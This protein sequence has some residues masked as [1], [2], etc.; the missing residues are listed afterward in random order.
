M[1]C[2]ERC[3]RIMEK[4][5]SFGEVPACMSDASERALSATDARRV[6]DVPGK[7]QRLLRK[8]MRLVEPSILVIG[9]REPDLKHALHLPRAILS[10]L[11]N[12]VLQCDKRLVEITFGQI[13]GPQIPH[14]PGSC[15]IMWGDCQGVLLR[16]R[17]ALKVGT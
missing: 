4:G 12:S 17:D 7:G 6:L 11:L 1:G 15:K 10:G 5:S 14:K 13:G 16:V 3:Q 9:F 2:R 8:G